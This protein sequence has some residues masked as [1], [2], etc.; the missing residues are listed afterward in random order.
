MKS[1]RRTGKTA[2]VT[3]LVV[4]GAAAWSSGAAAQQAP[5]QHP[6]S[7]EHPSAEHP[8]I[9]EHPTGQPT[10][11]AA[12]AAAL[13]TTSATVEKI[14]K[15]KG[16]ITLKGAGGKSLEV[17]AGPGINLDK[18]RVGDRVDTAYFDEVAV[19]IRKASPGAPTMTTKAVER[20]GV[21]AMQ[22]TVTSRIV[23]VDAAKNTVTIKGPKAEEHTLKVTDPDLQS[24]LKDVKAGDHLDVTYT[25]AVAVSIE[26]AKKPEPAKKT[27]PK[28]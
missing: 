16:L 9:K 12:A 20:A 22:S 8:S 13:V 15:D 18:L 4:L 25:Q 3:A 1:C 17:K 21:A 28:K 10:P 27:E 23:S 7:T 24:R 11:G 19:D 2:A 5:A 26:P 6:S 14:D